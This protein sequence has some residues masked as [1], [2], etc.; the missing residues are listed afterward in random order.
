MPLI[1]R[2]P[3]WGTTRAAAYCGV[4]Y[5]QMQYWLKSGKLPVTAI[6]G[7][8]KRLVRRS[9]LDAYKLGMVPR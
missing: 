5:F 3:A 7:S 8:K 9:A 6:P 4:T 2:D 1:H